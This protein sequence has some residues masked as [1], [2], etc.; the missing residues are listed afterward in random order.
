VAVVGEGE[1]RIAAI[2]LI[3]A[4]AAGAGDELRDAVDRFEALHVMVVAR[5]DDRSLA[6]Q[7]A[8]E[9]LEVVLVAV[10]ASTKARAVPEGD[11]TGPGLGDRAP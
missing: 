1:T 6:A 8:P 5:H 7:G 11:A 3:E 2:D 10:L 4:S 9:R